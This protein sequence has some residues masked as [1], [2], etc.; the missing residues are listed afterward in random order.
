[1]KRIFFIPFVWLHLILGAHNKKEDSTAVCAIHCT[2]NNIAPAGI[3]TDH[4]HQRKH[5]SFAYSYM[6]MN[7]SGNKRGTNAVSDEQV[8]TNYMMSPSKMNMQMHMLMPMYGINNRLSI[9]AMI[10][11]SIIRMSMHEMPNQSQNMPD[12]CDMNSSSSANSNS[13]LGDV[14]LY[15]M[16]N[17]LRSCTHRLVAS[18]GVSLPTANIR[19][20]N[21]SSSIIPYCMQVGTGSYHILSSLVYVKEGRLFSFGAALQGSISTG[22]NKQGYRWGNECSVSP[23]LAY[24]P[25]KFM[26]IAARAEAYYAGAIQGWDNSINQLAGND[27][28][29]DVKNYGSQQRLDLF[30]GLNFYVPVASSQTACVLIEYGKPLYQNLQGLQ[31]PFQN[32]LNLRLQYNF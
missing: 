10:P 4:V 12:M 1:M 9:M 22:S 23:W 27:P 31:M 30:L 2:K 14:K 8:F 11:Y 32:I 13:G 21:T 28:S 25:I 15:L 17:F 19:S 20:A 26:G 7:M 18:A 16:Y 3:M 6:F 24:K 29:A 5:F